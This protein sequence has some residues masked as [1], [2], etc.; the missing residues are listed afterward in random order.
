MLPKA[1]CCERNADVPRPFPNTRR[2]IKSMSLIAI[3][4]FDQDRVRIGEVKWSALSKLWKPSQNLTDSRSFA[5]N[6]GQDGRNGRPP[7]P[8]PALPAERQ[9]RNRSWL[10]LL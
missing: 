8:Q 7:E 9:P 10:L 6:F 1:I 2:L 3:E 5:A 4:R